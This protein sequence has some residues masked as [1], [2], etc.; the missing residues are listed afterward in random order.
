MRWDQAAG[1]GFRGC[2]SKCWVYTEDFSEQRDRSRPK[3]AVESNRLCRKSFV[4]IRRKSIAR[5]LFTSSTCFVAVRSSLINSRV[6]ILSACHPSRSVR[7]QPKIHRL[8]IWSSNAIN[9]MC[10]ELILL[11]KLGLKEHRNSFGHF[12]FCCSIASCKLF[13]CKQIIMQIN[14]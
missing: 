14:L 5:T 3:I 8:S 9:S 12:R 10:I 11:M 4:G 7:I 1:Q 2:R 6:L 13:T